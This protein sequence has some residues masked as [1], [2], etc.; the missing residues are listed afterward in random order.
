MLEEEEKSGVKMNRTTKELDKE[1]TK[2]QGLPSVGSGQCEAFGSLQPRALSAFLKV[3]FQDGLLQFYIRVHYTQVRKHTSLLK[4][5]NFLKAFSVQVRVFHQP[6]TNILKRSCQAPAFCALC[7][8]Q[9]IYKKTLCQVLK[10]P[11]K[12][13]NIYFPKGTSRI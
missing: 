5:F 3:S 9:Y 4:Q 6:C 11:L 1:M 12:K 13:D 10:E 2:G 7:V 8:C